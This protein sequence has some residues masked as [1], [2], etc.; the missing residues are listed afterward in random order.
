MEAHEKGHDH[1]RDPVEKAEAEQIIPEEFA[2]WIQ[3]DVEETGAA[4]ELMAIGRLELAIAIDFGYKLG[5][6][7]LG[8]VDVAR[9]RAN[10]PLPH[11]DLMHGALPGTPV[12]LGE[13]DEGCF[14]RLPILE[15]ATEEVGAAA[16]AI[17]SGRPTPRTDFDNSFVELG[18]DGL[19]RIQEKDP[20]RFGRLQKPVARGGKVCHIG[21]VEREDGE[22]GWPG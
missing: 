18:R 12:A 5:Q 19:V 11:P 13:A 14:A 21:L 22:I 2:Q 3:G 6:G 10:T 16:E 17:G 8:V 7:G 20:L 1:T 15:D 4:A 9:E